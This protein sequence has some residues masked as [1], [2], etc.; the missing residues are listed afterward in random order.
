MTPDQAPTNLDLLV[1]AMAIGFV[2]WFVVVWCS[3]GFWTWVE[4]QLLWRRMRR[5]R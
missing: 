1:V 4:R 3:F 2:G 5:P